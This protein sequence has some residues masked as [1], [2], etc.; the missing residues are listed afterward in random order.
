MGYQPADERIR[1]LQTEQWS[2]SHEG[3]TV[4]PRRIVNEQ[5]QPVG[6]PPYW[7]VS[8]WLYG[9]RLFIHHVTEPDA[10]KARGAVYRV[11]D[12]LKGHTERLQRV[13]LANGPV[14]ASEAAQKAAQDVLGQ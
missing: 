8:V 5:G 7:A 1:R 2:E 14:A 9:E 11:L 10:I 4:A 6:G 13:C 3:L 12:A